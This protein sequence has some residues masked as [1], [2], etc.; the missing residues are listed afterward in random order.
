MGRHN[1][2]VEKRAN[3][4]ILEKSPYLLQHAYNP[5]DWYPWGSEAFMKARTENKLIFLSIGYSTCHWCHVM[6][7]ESF[8]DPIVA[9]LLNETFISI[10]VDREER[11]DIDSTYMKICQM[12]TGSGGWPLNIIMTPNRK[13]LFATTY[14]P[15]EGRFNRIGI[16]ELIPRI[17]ELWKS[18]RHE[19]ES[20]AEGILSIFKEQVKSSKDRREE[21]GKSTLD[22]A[23]TYLLSRFDKI[24]G[25]FGKTPKFPTAHNLS[26]LLRYWKRSGYQKALQMVERTLRAMRLGGI[27]DHLGFGFHRYS[28]DSKWIV[29]H[30]EKML[31]DQAMLAIAYLE[32]YQATEKKEYAQTVYEILTYVL[33]DMTALN[34]GFYSA[35][36]ADSEGEE[37]KFYVWTEDEIK[38]LLHKKEGELITR[39]FSIE[40]DGN[41]EDES[42]RRRTG[43]NILYMRN[44]LPEVAS[45]LGI[46]PIELSKRLENARQSLYTARKKRIHPNKD[47]K[48]LTDWNGL[49]I[50]ALAKAASILNEDA[51]LTAAKKAANFIISKMTNPKGRLYHRYRDGESAIPGFLSDYSLFIWGLIE[52][53]EATFETSYLK[54][55]INLTKI[56]IKHFWDKEKGGFYFT[57]DD[58]EN[59]LIREKLIY[60]GAYP[61]GNSIAALNT[62]RLGRMTANPEFEEKAKQIFHAFSSIISETPAGY[63]QFMVAL[64]FA[65]GP[66]FE[67]VIVGHSQSKDTE[68]MLKAVK[69]KFIPNKIL[70]LL[71]A[72][73]QEPEITRLAKYTRHLITKEG[74]ATA[75]VCQDYE[76]NLPTIDIE[77]AISL[78]NKRNMHAH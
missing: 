71:P 18:R 34:G 21:L 72:E 65:L 1:G 78:L 77:K 64:D 9:K 56:M 38:R 61:S 50:V 63:T 8:E 28:T 52:L 23:F 13:P 51:Y 25:G 14:I 39:I 44:S 68:L 16:K 49:M 55:A 3:R 73:V 45:K 62:I 74:K 33:R 10:K 12:M 48:I 4:L 43:K 2:S 17:K 57:A 37:G 35:E 29:P 11:P 69:S 6:E 19:L 53:Y 41:F 70:L 59:V 15:K 20:S 36:D 67:V 76:C 27:Y 32:A 58:A 75:Y 40:P 7:K 60:D 42:T 30:F 26:F 47:D 66:S 24:Y 22:E 54:S 5:V 46:L 31:C